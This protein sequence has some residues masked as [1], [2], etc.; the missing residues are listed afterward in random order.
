MS[1]QTH[2]APQGAWE[3]TEGDQHSFSIL[4]KSHLFSQLGEGSHYCGFLGFSP[5]PSLGS[6]S[7]AWNC[8]FGLIPLPPPCDTSRNGAVPGKTALSFI[9]FLLPR[10]S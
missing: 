6:V 2:T 1:A 8:S 7:S 10:Q 9:I 4:E 3:L 5:H